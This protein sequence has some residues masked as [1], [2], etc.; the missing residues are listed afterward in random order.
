MENAR[1]LLDLIAA[2]LSHIYAFETRFDRANF[3][4]II[5]ARKSGNYTPAPNNIIKDM[6]DFFIQEDWNNLE[7]LYAYT[8]SKLRGLIPEDADGNMIMVLPRGLCD[9]EKVER[10]ART[11]QVISDNE[12]IVFKEEED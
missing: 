3:G 12:N 4:D 9:S 2:K 6:N 7:N 8:S 5:A 1:M 11:A 10:I